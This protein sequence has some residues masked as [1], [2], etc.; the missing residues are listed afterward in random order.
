MIGGGR[1]Q[2]LHHCAG[3]RGSGDG[4]GNLLCLEVSAIHYVGGSSAKV[5]AMVTPM[6]VASA[7]EGVASPTLSSLGE[8]PVHRRQ[9]TVASR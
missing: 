1:P 6:G 8:S 9:A 7:V 3:R 5:L 2:N 4:E